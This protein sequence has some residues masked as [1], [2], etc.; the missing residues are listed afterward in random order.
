M[1]ERS[2][3]RIVHH[4]HAADVVGNH[5]DEGLDVLGHSDGRI[6]TEIELFGDV[7]IGRADV[8]GLDQVVEALLVPGDALR[9]V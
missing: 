7:I 1:Q 3:V 5:F 8:L 9:S 2:V 4:G 6:V